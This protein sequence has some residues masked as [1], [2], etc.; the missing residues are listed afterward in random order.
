MNLYLIRHGEPKSEQEDP[1]RPLSEK[2]IADIQKLSAFLSE[3]YDIQVQ[4]IMHSPKLR[5]KQTAEI[6]SDYLHPHPRLEEV[7]GLKPLDDPHIWK[8]RLS[9]MTEDIILAGHLPHLSELASLLLNLEK[10]SD[11]I[12]FAA[13][14]MVCFQRDE[15]GTWSFQWSIKPEDTT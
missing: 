8:D 11:R 15:S 10:Y 13:G 12:G 6:L 1:Q 5:A 14:E 9:N 7:S 3:H 2:G 4:K